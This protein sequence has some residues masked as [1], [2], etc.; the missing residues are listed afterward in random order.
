[1]ICLTLGHAVTKTNLNTLFIVIDQLRADCVFGALAGS[2][3][4][5]N[6]R[7]LASDGVSFRNHYSVTSPCGPSRVSLLTAQYASNHGA[8]RN[9]TP[10]KRDVPNLATVAR[11]H[12]YDPLLFGYT[13][14]A[15]D[16]RFLPPDDPRLFSYEELAP[17]FTEVVRMRMEGDSTEWET[18]LRSHGYDVPPYPDL[19]RP[20]GDR[21]DGPAL[22]GAAHSDTAFLTDRAISELDRRP[23]GWMALLTYIRPHPPFVAPAPYNTMYK[24]TDMPSA[25]QA[26]DP[27]WHPFVA[28][29]RANSSVASTV[30][31]FP[32]LAAS[33]QT[34][35]MIR[36][37]YF[38]LATE[39]DHHIGRVLDWLKAT[40]R[41]DDTLVVLT[42]DHGEMLGDYDL[43][44]KR[45]FH[46]A[47]FH[48]PLIIR[49]PRTSAR[50]LIVTDPTESIDVTPTILDRLGLEVPHS[51]DGKSLSPFLEGQAPDDWRQV[52]VSELDFGDP[53]SPT[54]WQ[55]DYGLSIDAANLAVLRRGSLR[56]V[57]FAGGLPPIL[58]DV[59]DGTEARNLTKKPAYVQTMLDL[60]QELLCHR[61]VNT[62]GT[63]SKT[64]ITEDG[65]KVAS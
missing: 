19:Y 59:S 52:T 49:D 25:R 18:Y 20:I 5:P 7:A 58:L 37:L 56:F 29:A 32:D 22:Y 24:A 46:D 38:G 14:T 1:M 43:W 31:G 48:V 40:G 26:E 28:T 10:L 64:L 8:T 39:V 9:G 15:Q 54:P 53:V 27:D 36:A 47:A 55:I 57:Q 30:V 16:P 60:M 35:R 42:A 61:M 3:D 4:L 11:A 2:V 12:G 50:G 21:P 65:V 34:T 63:F 17:G 41:L 33:D 62:D 45:T 23:D 44:G 51:M 13:D 6:I